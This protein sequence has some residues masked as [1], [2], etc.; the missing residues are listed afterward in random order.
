MVASGLMDLRLW[1]CMV[2]G[3]VALRGISAPPNI[4]E[5][6]EERLGDIAGPAPR[7]LTTGSPRGCTTGPCE[8]LKLGEAEERSQL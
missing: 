4:A 5:T 6:L 2:V 3:L 7:A 1:I 8:L